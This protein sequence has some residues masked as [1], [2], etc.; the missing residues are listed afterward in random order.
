MP[1]KPKFIHPVRFVRQTVKMSQPAF[2]KLI[3]TSQA[4]IQSVELG[5]LVV[6]KRL[7]RRMG[8]ATGVDPYSVMKNRGKPLDCDGKPYSVDSFNRLVKSPGKFPDAD[9]T[10]YIEQ[11]ILYFQALAEASNGP[12]KFRFSPLM[13]SLDEWLQDAR[14]EFGLEKSADAALKRLSLQRSGKMMLFKKWQTPF[15]RPFL[16]A[17]PTQSGEVAGEAVAN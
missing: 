16:Y 6:S 9:A 1:K 14:K 2:A 7:A 13:A 17:D 5:R 10:L 3:G 11:A 4:T 12:L 8:G 15:F